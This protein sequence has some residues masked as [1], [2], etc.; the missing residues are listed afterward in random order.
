MEF[1]VTT[2]PQHTAGQA[3]VVDAMSGDRAAMDALWHEHRRWIAAVLLAHKSPEDQVEDLLQEVA[4]TIV[5]K[6]NTLREAR[7]VRAWLRT[8]A[9][10]AARASARSRRARPKLAPLG[11]DPL[12]PDAVSAAVDDE[13]RRLMKLSERL[14]D[15]YREPLMLRALHGMRGRHIA[16]ILDL[17]E[18]TVETRIARARRMLRELAAGTGTDDDER[19]PVVTAGHM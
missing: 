13:A 6:I 8:V 19:A 11:V 5:A 12:G 9:I 18:A 2:G 10:N 17:S 16:E 14:S 3:M 15:T 4:M 7:Y 1:F